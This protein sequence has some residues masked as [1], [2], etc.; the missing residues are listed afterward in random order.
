VADAEHAYADVRAVIQDHATEALT[1]ASAFLQGAETVD[2][3]DKAFY[4]ALLP[5]V[6]SV[7]ETA[8]KLL[9]AALK[10]A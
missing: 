7:A 10:A 6:A 8:A 4:E 3:A 2:P 9:G 5:K 1:L